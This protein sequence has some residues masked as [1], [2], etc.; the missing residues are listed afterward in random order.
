MLSLF[1]RNKK[2]QK[3][4]EVKLEGNS[5]NTHIPFG[6][7]LVLEIDS[8]VFVGCRIHNPF[9]FTQFVVEGGI[10]TVTEP[11]NVVR[12]AT[13]E[14]AIRIQYVKRAVEL[15]QVVCFLQVKDIA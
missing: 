3:V 12:E 5:F 8:K 14:E 7:D 11:V 15:N 9:L 6:K 2:E 1:K 10:L 4:S 13:T